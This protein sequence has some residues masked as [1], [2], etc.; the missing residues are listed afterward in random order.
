MSG[1]T[2]CPGLMESHRIPAEGLHC[3]RRRP[4]FRCARRL[5]P[6]WCRQGLPW[7][8]HQAALS[9]PYV[10]AADRATSYA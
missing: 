2:E 4:L 5:R 1:K 10:R 3:C 6:T 7:R 8:L 9:S